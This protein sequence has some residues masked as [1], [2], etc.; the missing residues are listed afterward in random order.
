MRTRPSQGCWPT[1]SAG[2][3]TWRSKDRASLDAL[4]ERAGAIDYAGWERIDAHER[5]TGE[6]QGRPRLKLVRV[7][8]MREIA[9]D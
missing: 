5:E 6:A 7:D 3:S 4:L 2:Q 8:S 1:A 9:G